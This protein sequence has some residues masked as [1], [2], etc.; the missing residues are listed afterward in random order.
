MQAPTSATRNLRPV[1]LI[2]SALMVAELFAA[3]ETGMV[4]AAMSTFIRTFGD[5]VSVGWLITAYL[6]VA[7]AS[8]AIGG[9]LGDLYGRKRLLLAVLAIAGMGSLISGATDN[10]TWVLTGRAMQGSVGAALPLCYGLVRENLPPGRVAWAFGIITGT[11]AVGAGVGVVS[12]GMIVDLL[13][14]QWLFHVSAIGS[15]ASFT[16][17]SVAIPRSAPRPPQGRL[18][19]LGGL[20]F[21]PAIFGVLIAVTKAGAWG[22]GDARTLGFLAASLALLVAWTMYELRHPNP[23]IDV[24]LL[25]HP[26][27]ALANVLM[28][29][30][31]LG[32]M[33]SQVAALLLQ[34]PV[35]TGVGFGLSATVAGLI[36]IPS[37]FVG[38]LGATWAG[39]VATRHGARRATILSLGVLCAGWSTLTVFH[40]RTWIV[41]TVMLLTG[42]GIA[43]VFASVPNLLVEVVPTERTSEATGLTAVVRSTFQGVGSQLVALSLASSVV[44]DAAHGSGR[45][46]S[47]Q[48]FTLT[49]GLIAVLCGVALLVAFW[50]P[51]RAPA[52]STSPAGA[53]TVPLK[54]TAAR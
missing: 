35:W 49:I 46:P 18:D 6:L 3:F 53:P 13:S 5:P 8:A 47:D 43:S 48:A 42:F 36:K 22:W 31:A 1:Y 34:Q 15:L 33:Q 37:N 24:R 9:R 38:A 32:A 11:A 26:Q 16:A 2:M 52:A 50:L 23:L 19:M 51:R 41:G 39:G 14:W 25:T 27:I 4:L 40:D 44:S 20:L 45:Y 17:I 54:E 28:A 21:V 7:A 12:G 30:A 29:L 10:F